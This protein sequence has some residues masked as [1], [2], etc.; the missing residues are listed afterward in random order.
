ME[1]QELT[2]YSEVSPITLNKR[3]DWRVVTSQLCR[4]NIPYKWGY[5]F[6]LLVNYKGQ[7]IAL[8]TK[9]Q[10]EEFIQ[11]LDNEEVEVTILNQGDNSSELEG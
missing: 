2:L 6:K 1:G 10:A 7:T 4:V 11:V 8:L 3:R 9:Q 5:T